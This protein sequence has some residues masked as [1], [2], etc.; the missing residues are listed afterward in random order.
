MSLLSIITL[1][2]KLLLRFG[3]YRIWS[4]G[5][6]EQGGRLYN[7]ANEAG[8][9]I[10]LLKTMKNTNYSVFIA[11]GVKDF[12]NGTA[13]MKHGE[14]PFNFTTT[15]FQVYTYPSNGLN[16]VQWKVCGYIK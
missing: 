9:I 7:N 3:W 16:T 13:Y 12:C 8:N 15:S 4:D 5:Y 11:H 14:E 1:K 10:T 2:T 6:C